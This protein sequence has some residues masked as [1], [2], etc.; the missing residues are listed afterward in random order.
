[1]QGPG[2][3]DVQVGRSVGREHH[4]RA[5]R[6]R[7]G[8]ISDTA[9]VTADCAT[10]GGTGTTNVNFNL[11]G[12]VTLNAPQVGGVGVSGL[13]RT[14]RNDEAYLLVGLSFL[15]ALAGVE[16]LRRRSRSGA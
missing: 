3:G 4:R 6:R 1:M 14:G 15:L 8:R 11:R 2:V 16:V 13:P 10:G 9:T 7:S 5:P 12:T